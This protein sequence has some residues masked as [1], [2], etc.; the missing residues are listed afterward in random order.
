MAW[1]CGQ[2]PLWTLMILSIRSVTI[3]SAPGS[4]VRAELLD[5]PG[6]ARI[7]ECPALHLAD[8]VHDGGVIAAVEG[9]GDGGEREVGE[10]SRQVHGELASP[11]D[12]GGA[13]GGED[14]L[15][16]EAEAGRNGL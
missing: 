13:G 5:R 6:E 16:A 7:L 1:I 11:G 12:G 3:H 4:E 10:L 9:V 15:D 2:P 8:G 14:R